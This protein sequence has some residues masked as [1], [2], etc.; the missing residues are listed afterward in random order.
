MKPTKAIVATDNNPI[1][2]PFW[3]TVS[4]F[5]Y[6]V[7]GIEPVLIYVGTETPTVMNLSDKYGEVVHFSIG[8]PFRSLGRW[9]GSCFQ[10]C[11]IGRSS[12]S[13]NS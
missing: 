9:A 3:N 5:W 6:K 7:I 11:V 12:A 4:K 1:Y 13:A 8:G 10:R 2:Y